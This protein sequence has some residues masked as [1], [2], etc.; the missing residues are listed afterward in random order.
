MKTCNRCGVEKPF[1]EFHKG[2][3]APDGYIYTCKPCIGVVK[4]QRRQELK[5]RSEEELTAAAVARGPRLCRRCDVVK[6]PDDYP[7]DRGHHTARGQYC[8]PCSAANTIKYR[9]VISPELYRARKKASYGRNRQTVRRYKLKVNF[10]IT[11]EQYRE[12]FAQQDG[13]CA[14]CR[15][16]EV[17]DRRG[18]GR[19]I[20]LS[21]DHDHDTGVVRRLLCGNCNRGL[22]NFQDSLELLEAALLY[23]REHKKPLLV[24]V[25]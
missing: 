22:G 20:D 19:V 12:M 16:P 6:A 23:L 21:V 5:N 10:G 1:S 18:E 4:R 8:K 2:G 7:V 17:T 13:L 11:L 3:L 14:I 25:E 9:T 24:A 15:Q